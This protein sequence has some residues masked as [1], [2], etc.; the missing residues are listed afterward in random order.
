MA[1]AHKKTWPML[2]HLIVEKVR[3]RR[4][5]GVSASSSQQS[6]GENSGQAAQDHTSPAKVNEFLKKRT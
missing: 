5:S 3:S 1:K 6:S 2:S 4:G